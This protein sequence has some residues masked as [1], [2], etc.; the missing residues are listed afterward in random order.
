M[1][2]RTRC[3]LLL[4]SVCC[5]KATFM[6]IVGTHLTF[7]QRTTRLHILLGRPHLQ[8]LSYKKVT[9]FRPT[10]STVKCRFGATLRILA[11]EF[12]IIRHSSFT[13]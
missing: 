11:K 6:T 5:K 10:P 9:C 1:R 4:R 8:I 7:I 3:F 12:S 2:R 13:L